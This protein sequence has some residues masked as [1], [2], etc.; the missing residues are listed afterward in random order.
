MMA[1]TQIDLDED[2]LA[3]AMKAS[4]VTTKKAVVNLALRE[5]AER[6]RRAEARLQH[7]AAAQSWDD[8]SFWEQR[9][10][11]KVFREAPN[12]V[13]PHLEGEISRGFDAE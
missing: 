4:G 1:A 13:P 5:F 3:A 12:A 7:F 8:T 10:A 2:A 6:R 9:A 11:G